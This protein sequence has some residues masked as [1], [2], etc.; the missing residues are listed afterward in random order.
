[1]HTRPRSSTVMCSKQQT[2]T[3]VNR[4]QAALPGERPWNIEA[5]AQRPY[6]VYGRILEHRF[7]A[8][9]SPPCLFESARG[10]E[11]EPQFCQQVADG[12]AGFRRHPTTDS[13]AQLVRA[14]ASHNVFCL[15]WLACEPT[16][17]C[18]TTLHSVLRIGGVGSGA[19]SR[20]AA[21]VS[22]GWLCALKP[23]RCIL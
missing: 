6:K 1:M 16:L 8:V 18:C 12:A 5:P 13:I 7:E 21:P 15:F 22:A 2:H 4:S 19:W 9:K 20:F 17:V 3:H 23:C 14:R 11:F 10:P